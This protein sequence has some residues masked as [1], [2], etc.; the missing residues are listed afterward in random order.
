[1]SPVLA[2]PL[3]VGSLVVTLAA[4]RVFARR[5][6]RIGVRFGFPEPLIG[7]LTAVAADGPEICTAL[8][9]LIKGAH[10]VSVGVLMGSNVFNLAAMLGLSALLVGS[11][12]LPREA[13]LLEGL[14]GAFATA[15]TAAVLLGWLPALPAVLLLGC[16]LVPYVLLLIRGPALLRRLPVANQVLDR[17]AGVFSYRQPVDRRAVTRATRPHHLV[18]L[19]V[20]DV[21]LI[22]AGSTGMV[23][24][25]LALGDR[26][27]ISGAVLGVLILAPLTSIPNALTA[28]R[29]GLVAPR[30]GARRRDLQ[31]QHDQPRRRGDS[32]GV[33]RRRR[34]RLRV[35][36]IRCRVARGNDHRVPVPAGAPW[37]NA[38]CRGGR[39]DLPLRDVRGSPPPRR[40]VEPGCTHSRAERGKQR[41]RQGC[42]SG[43]A[44][45]QAKRD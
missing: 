9:A 34:Q 39:A 17:V 16:V 31:Q 24:A 8:V 32:P 44:S 4:A 45:A 27:R 2:A 7:L 5:L 29:L 15:T 35:G 22:V 12:R 21:A 3:F 43:V 19:A 37:W 38:T 28:V 36:E 40:I 13:L 41:P 20:L 30:I 18:A 23:Q 1:M 42:G 10:S 11:V 33:V 25:A 6:D 26:W 14:V